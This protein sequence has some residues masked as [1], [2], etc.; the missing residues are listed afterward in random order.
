MNEPLNPDVAWQRALI[1]RLASEGQREGTRARRWRNFF[2]F[3]GF[4]FAFLLLASVMGWLDWTTSGGKSMTG[5]HT[6]VVKLEGVID[7]DGRA[8][9]ENVID[10]L[11]AAYKSPGAKGVILHCN[12]PGGSPVQA[13]RI[14]VE[15][16]RL[17]AANKEVPLYVVVDEVCASGGYYAAVAA[18]KIYV[19]P[20][21]IVGSIGVIMDGF[22]AVG[23]MEK[24][25]FERRTLTAGD[26]KAMMDP[27]SPVN[28]KHKEHLQT[29]L[30]DVHAQFIKVVKDG[31]G[32]RLKAPDAEAFS[33]LVYS[34][35]KSVAL[36]FADGIG[37]VDSVARDIFKAEEI[38]DYTR[39]ESP[40]ARLSR[41]IGTSFGQG[42]STALGIEMGKVRW[43]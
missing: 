15:M 8:S 27:F 39:E 23:A 16:K 1:E 25:G 40:F 19:D 36:G 13:N 42:M 4:T 10:G 32:G 28:P 35:E 12:T 6:A 29:M 9:A 38:V 5:A 22:G 3:L 26:N 43:R 17:R 41:R 20:S 14:N 24:L 11:R 30:N 21:S 7:A 34:G 33:G 18:E 37:D 31:R 2:R